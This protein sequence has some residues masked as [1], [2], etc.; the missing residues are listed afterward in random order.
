L[1]SRN[2]VRDFDAGSQL[3]LLLVTAVATVLLIRLFL[4]LTGFPQLGGDRL[5]IAHMLWGGLG[6][7]VA[8]VIL[9]SFISRRGRKLAA[10]IGGAGFGAF[11]DEVGK[12]VTQ[13]NDY[14]FQPAISIIYIVFIL[15]YLAIRW[16]HAEKQR[17][18]REYLSN[19]LNEVHEVIAGDLDAVERDRAIAYLENCD[20][21]NQWVAGLKRLL[22]TTNVV[23]PSKPGILIRIRNGASAF[24]RRIASH[25]WFGSIVIVFFVGQLFIRI[26]A[27][28]VV[29]A[30]GETWLTL[31]T[32]QRVASL[33]GD[34][35]Q[36][37]YFEVSLI[38]FSV[39]DAAFV[40]AGAWQL[41][42]S[43]LL[44]FQM[45]QRSVFVSLFL[46][47]PLMFYRDQWSALIGLSFDFAVFFALRFVIEREQAP[48]HLT[49]S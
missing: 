41:R 37:S 22:E 47:Q 28:V 35:T 17:T 42:K 2:F 15:T 6:M 32:R 25:P 34:G 9:L 21:N 36:I 24:Y 10:F 14:F 20:S 7:L 11:I 39:L 8:I 1:Q 12:F 43:R 29:L 38:L 19:A 16:L 4:E 46:I 26:V 31:L 27:I 3:D 45:F 40:A 30:S 48:Q 5:H 44:A 18:Q 13:D 33:S 23:D 49:G